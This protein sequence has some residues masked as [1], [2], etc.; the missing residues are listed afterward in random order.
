MD[1][2]NKYV[3]YVPGISCSLMSVSRIA[4]NGLVTVFHDNM[5]SIYPK[6]SVK[7]IGDPLLETTENN[8]TSTT[9]DI[10]AVEPRISGS[11]GTY[12]CH[13]G[14]GIMCIYH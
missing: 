13:L 7:I 2:T 6:D 10:G 9:D 1:Y 14:F 8:G 4:K 3:T 12:R 11:V 5:C